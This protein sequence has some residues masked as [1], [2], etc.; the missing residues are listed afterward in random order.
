M[1]VSFFQ[2]RV[3]PK[4]PD[5][6]VSVVFEARLPSLWGNQ[7]TI[8]WQIRKLLGIESED[9]SR[10]GGILRPKFRAEIPRSIL[11]SSIRKCIEEDCTITIQ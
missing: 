10:V 5:E 1:G 11:S 7:R 2:N 8:A 3:P 4:D 6:I 9:L